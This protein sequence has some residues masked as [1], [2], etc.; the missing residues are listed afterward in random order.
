MIF[1]SVFINY[2]Y[3]LTSFDF[4]LIFYNLKQY[5]KYFMVIPKILS[6][7]IELEFHEM[8]T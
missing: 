8:I 6:S 5:P 1:L 7:T 2:I 3:V 4:T